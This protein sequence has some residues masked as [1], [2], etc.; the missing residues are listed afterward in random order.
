MVF[1]DP[2]SSLNPSHTVGYHLR[3]P[4][5]LHGAADSRTTAR[6]TTLAC[7]A[8]QPHAPERV[9]ERYPHELSGGQRQRVA[10]ARALAPDPHPA[11]RRARLDARLSIRLE[12][13]N[14]ID[15]SSRRRPRRPV[16]DHDLA[17]AVLRHRGDGDVPGQIVESGPSD[18]VI[19]RPAHPYTQLLAAAAPDPGTPRTAAPGPARVAGG[20]NGAD[21]TGCL[22]RP[23]PARDGDLQDDGT[24]FEVGT[25][26]R[27]AA[28]CTPD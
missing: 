13:L 20:G 15:R 17:T 18:E 25:A 12:I 28:S 6:D 14:L 8:G 4:L 16:R 23:V 1:Q 19:L 9:I 27:A 24:T 10:I 21:R 11:R 2:F 26:H 3:R 7:S 22:F 5:L